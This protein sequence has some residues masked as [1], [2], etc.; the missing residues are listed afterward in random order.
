MA[1][2][3]AL[4]GMLCWGVA[5]LFG[6]VGLKS[7]DSIT[8]LVLRTLFA[9]TMVS[10]WVFLAPNFSTK[11]ISPR[12]CFFIA[13][14]A[15]LATLIGDLSYFV[16]LRRG[17]INDVTLIMSTSPLVTMILSY[18]FLS[19]SVYLYHIIGAVLIIAG[20]ILIGLQPKF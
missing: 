8:A 9:G 6:K 16:A 17:N 20:L 14:E 19:E 18:F 5:P 10:A 15:I 4:F 12:T 1:V 7:L 2:I 13:A 11:N 3:Y